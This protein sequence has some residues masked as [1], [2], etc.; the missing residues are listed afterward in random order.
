MSKHSKTKGGSPYMFCY[1]LRPLLT[2]GNKLPP[3]F[4]W[5]CTMEKCPSTSS[6]RLKI[7]CSGS[8]G[9]DSL[10]HLQTFFKFFFHVMLHV[11]FLRPMLGFSDPS[12]F[13]STKLGF[14]DQTAI[15]CW[16]FPTDMLVFFDRLLGI[17]R[18][19]CWDFSTKNKAKYLWN[20]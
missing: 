5:K 15:R 12:W 4:L 6:E 8:K 9:R 17:F 10:W 13:S 11:G 19:T 1:K 7:I 3:I 2:V 16:D 14:S 18:P 20:K